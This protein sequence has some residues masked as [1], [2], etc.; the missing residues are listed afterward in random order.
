MEVAAD[1][2]VTVAGRSDS[3]QVT[4]LDPSIFQVTLEGRRVLVYLAVQ[5]TRGW[6]FADGCIF[7]LDLEPERQSLVQTTDANLAPSPH[8]CRPR[9]AAFSSSPDKPHAREIRG[10]PGSDEDGVHTQG[11]AKRPDRDTR[12]R[13]RWSGPAKHTAGHIDGRTHRT[14]W[15]MTLRSRRQITENDT[16]NGPPSS[17]SGSAGRADRSSGRICRQSGS[18]ALRCSVDSAAGPWL[19]ADRGHV[20]STQ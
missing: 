19:S 13:R 1:G 16:C 15:L 9:C 18:S 2:T 10:P 12:L 11:A 3:V 4:C 6:A 14:D 8:P 17:R 20:T 5:M 7:E